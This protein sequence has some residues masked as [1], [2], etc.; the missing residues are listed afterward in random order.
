MTRTIALYAAL[1]GLLAILFMLSL[2]V[3]PV[4]LPLEAWLGRGPDTY[5]TIF[6]QL[7]LPRAILGACVGGALGLS[8]AAL[9]G[10][11]RN[12]LADPGV[13]HAKDRHLLQIRFSRRR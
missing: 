4:V 2:A 8:G 10:Y 5:A 9:Q 1:G 6:L 13:L 3:G 11:T 7:R 12:P